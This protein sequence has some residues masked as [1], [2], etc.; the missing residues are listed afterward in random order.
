MSTCLAVESL[1]AGYHRKEIVHDVDLSVPVGH[2]VTLI[3]PNGAG[4][5]TFLLSLMGLIRSSGSARFEGEEITGLPVQERVRLGISLVSEKRDLFS[6]LTVE[7]NLVLG[8]YS[9]NRDALSSSIEEVFALFPKLKE[10]RRQEAATL[11]GGERQMLAMGRALMAKPKLLLLDEPSLGLAPLIVR[12]IFAIIR[13]LQQTGISILLVEQNARAALNV[14]TSAYVLELG[15]VVLEGP[16]EKLAE[17]PR[18]AAS[19]LGS[20]DNRSLSAE[21]ET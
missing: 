10:R 1:C 14:A 15:R 17:D 2:V 19:Y 4:K 13:T 12:D 16:A 8:C 5:S 7:D 6:T 21:A 9:R 20:T 11:S 3:G 18:V